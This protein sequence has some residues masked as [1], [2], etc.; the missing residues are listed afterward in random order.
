[1]GGNEGISF[2]VRNTLG[3]ELVKLREVA[4]L[5]MFH[6]Y[7]DRVARGL[8]HFALEKGVVE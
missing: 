3:L 7:S 2:S 1:M 4:C 6:W 5:K 8:Q